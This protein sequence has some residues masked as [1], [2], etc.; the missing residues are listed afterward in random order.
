V[1]PG[2][3]PALARDKHM[4][5]EGNLG[6]HHLIFIET[7]KAFLEA[8]NLLQ[9]RAPDEYVG[10]TWWGSRS[11]S[12]RSSSSGGGTS[13][14]AATPSVRGWSRSWSARS[15]LQLCQYSVAP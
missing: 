12:D 7:P 10:R 3:G 9:N 6:E 8:A 14:S 15:P 11:R 4:N 13:E 5:S 1:L 2:A